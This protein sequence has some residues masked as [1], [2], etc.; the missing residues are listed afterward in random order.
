MMQIIIFLFAA[1]A[2]FAVD[3]VDCPLFNVQVLFLT[4]SS[5]S[6]KYE[7]KLNVHLASLT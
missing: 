6:F 3:C 1:V 2:V 4:R 7:R 5:I